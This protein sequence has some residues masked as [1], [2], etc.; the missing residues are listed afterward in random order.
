MLDDVALRFENAV[1]HMFTIALKGA[2][3]DFRL[4]TAGELSGFHFC[5]DDEPFLT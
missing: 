1:G 4:A 3:T 2:I 5:L